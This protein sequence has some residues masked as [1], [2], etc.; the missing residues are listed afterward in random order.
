M[1]GKIARGWTDAG[2]H[3]EVDA[4]LRQARQARVT[5]S[6]PNPFAVIFGPAM[7]GR[8]LRIVLLGAE[9][10]IPDGLKV[11]IAGR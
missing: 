4:E 1:L 10:G 6:A 11:D 9:P 5:D 2:R 3:V 7:I 8:T